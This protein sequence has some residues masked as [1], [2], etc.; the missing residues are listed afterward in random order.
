MNEADRAQLELMELRIGKAVSEVAS[1][2]GRLN[3]KLVERGGILDRLDNHEERIAG[4]EKWRWGLPLTI[5]L[6]A[7][8]VIGAVIGTR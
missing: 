3:E 1:G 2:V 4:Q 5:L 6:S 7:G 8:A